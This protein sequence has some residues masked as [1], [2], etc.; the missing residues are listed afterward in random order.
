MTC[1][2]FRLE[3]QWIPMSR[4]ALYLCINAGMIFL[5]LREDGDTNQED[6]E[7]MALYEQVTDPACANDV[8]RAGSGLHGT[9]EGRRN[10]QPTRMDTCR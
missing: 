8:L 2:Y 9:L 4:N 5:L 3:P 6:E 1:Q 7:A 10:D